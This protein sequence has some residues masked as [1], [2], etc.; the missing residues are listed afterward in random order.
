MTFPKNALFTAFFMIVFFP[1][2]RS[3]NYTFD[4]AGIAPDLRKNASIVVRNENI[5][6]ET[7]DIGQSRLH[8]HRIETV[9]NEK[10]KSALYFAL[11]TDKFII[12]DDLDIK[13]Y[14]ASG[15][16]IYKVKQHDLHTIAGVQEFI[17]DYKTYY[18][19]MPVAMYPVTIDA[20]YKIKYRGTFHFPTWYILKPDESVEHAEFHA[21]IK[22]DVGLRYKEKNIRLTPVITN[23]GEYSIYRWSVNNLSVIENEENSVNYLSRYPT[24]LL[25]PEWFKLGDYPGNMSTWEDF[26]RWYN[27]LQSGSDL[28]PEQR[29]VFYRELAK[30]ASSD[31]EKEIIIYR[32]LQ[33]NFRYVSIQLGIGGYKPISAAITDVNKYG[34]CKGLSNY[35]IAVLKVVGIQSYP[36]LIQAGEDQEPVDADF[37]SNRFNHMIVCI[38]GKKDSVWLECTSK[39]N[40]F[41]VLGSFTENRNALLITEKGGVLVP[42]PISR[43]NNNTVSYYTRINLNENGSGETN[44]VC[45]VSGQYKQNFIA[46]MDE[47]TDDQNWS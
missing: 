17:D 34:D 32:Y 16:T 29:K 38:P 39:T 36:A 47:K 25:A 42:T 1:A 44:T 26:G 37:P 35:L 10:G 8:I 9:L 18:L 11:Q 7:A 5:E 46:L 14:D 31:R 22:N 6:F 23:D 41:G 13:V 19:D 2:L 45:T 4:T 28:L 30:N 21:R 12:L 40:D 43:S 20:D 3:Q 33:N 24:I 15:K 27:D